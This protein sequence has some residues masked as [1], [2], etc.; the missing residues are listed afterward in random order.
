MLALCYILGEKYY[1]VPYDVR[2]VAGYVIGAGLLIW[3]VWQFPIANLWVA[4]PVHLALCGLFLGMVLLIE[5]NTIKPLVL[6][7]QKR[8]D[9]KPVDKNQD[10]VR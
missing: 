2:S 4:V 9:K 8:V 7:F 6:Q 3:A 1:P 10:S 5:R